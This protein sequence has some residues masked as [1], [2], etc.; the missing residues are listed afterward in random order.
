MLSICIVSFNT[1]QL[2]KNCIESIYENSENIQFEIIVVDNNSYDGSAEMIK[3]AFPEVKL[4][5]NESNA[6]YAKAVNQAIEQANGQYLLVLNSDTEILPNA[7]I[8]SLHFVKNRIDA[9]IVGCRLLNLDR[10]LQRYCRSFPSLL[11]FFSENFYLS[12]IFPNSKIFGRPFLYFFNYNEIKEVD[13]VAGAFMIVRKELIDQIGL[14]DDQFFMYSEEADWC[15]RAKKA[16]WKVYFYPGAEIIHYG[17][18]S[19]K[20]NSLKMFIELHKSH[21]KFISKYHG[22]FYLFLVKLVLIS[23]LLI[24]IVLFSS[25]YILKSCGVKIRVNPVKKLVVYWN[26]IKWYF[27]LE[28]KNYRE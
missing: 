20:Q 2:L 5:I 11:N 15:Y 26:T 28:K 25:L 16:G 1:R 22:N 19:T 3:Q 18:E 4:F 10:S 23:G 24:R 27:S 14:M 17:G 6:G 13:I 12:Y 9:G 8:K 21:H 7:L